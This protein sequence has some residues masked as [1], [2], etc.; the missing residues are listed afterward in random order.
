MIKFHQLPYIGT[1]DILKTV[2]IDDPTWPDLVQVP[3][4]SARILR[5]SLPFFLFQMAACLFSV[6]SLGRQ[7]NARVMAVTP[8]TVKNLRALGFRRRLCVPPV[9]VGM[10]ADLIHGGEAARDAPCFD[11]VYVGRFHPNKGFLDLPAIVA[12][13]KR[14]TEREVNVAVCGSPPFQRHLEMFQKK[15]RAYSVEGNRAMLGWRSRERLYETIRESKAL[16]YPSY[17]DAFSST[18]LESLC[19][20]VHVV[21]YG[22]DA[23]RT[24]WAYRKGVFLSPV[25]DP[26][27]FARRYA[28]IDSDSRLESAREQ[29]GNQTAEFLQEYTWERAVRYERDFYELGW[30]DAR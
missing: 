26:E 20:R 2:G 15:V 12:H 8:V 5:D 25:G 7:R 21:A 9:H 29:A 14:F 30:E 16:L 27:A 6:R 3:F 10:E 13:L 11:G 24:I 19:L 23:L 28:N 1:L 17:V 18:V 4:L 22:I